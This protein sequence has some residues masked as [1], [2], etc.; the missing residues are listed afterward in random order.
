MT[1]KELPRKHPCHHHEQFSFSQS[2]SWNQNEE[3]RRP[4]DMLNFKTRENLLSEMP[5]GSVS[6]RSC[7]SE[8]PSGN[9]D[10]PSKHDAWHRV[11][12]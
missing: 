5:G 4:E 7:I 10:F 8:R 9:T 3:E 1:L 11:G 12:A 6:F 2:K